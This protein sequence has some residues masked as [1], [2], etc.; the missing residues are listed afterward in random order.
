M[1]TKTID[2]PIHPATAGARA[3]G[4]A[5]RVAHAAHEAG[6][7][8]TMAADAAETGRYAVTRAI[9]RG[10]R[11]LEDLRDSAAYRVKRAPLV[12]V[13]VAFAAGM[14]TAVLSAQCARVLRRR[15]APEEW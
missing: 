15:A 2:P 9:T 13:G 1:T 7:L 12:A 3:A 6:L 5:R 14:L 8:K 11:D 4:V 10:R